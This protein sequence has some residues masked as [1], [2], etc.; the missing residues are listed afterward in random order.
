MENREERKV[1]KDN[2]RKLS[3]YVKHQIPRSLQ[4]DDHICFL[5]QQPLT[6][7]MIIKQIF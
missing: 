3:S 6:M 1:E 7:I 4:T 2:N 5:S